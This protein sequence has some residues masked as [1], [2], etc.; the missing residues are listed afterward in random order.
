MPH[1][2]QRHPRY[3]RLA[4]FLVVS[5]FL[6]LRAPYPI[7]DY[8]ATTVGYP[9]DPSLPSRVERAELAYRQ[10]VEKRQSL[11]RKHGPSPSQVL[12]YVCRSSLGEPVADIM[13]RFP[14]DHE[15]WPAYTVCE[16]IHFAKRTAGRQ[17]CTCRGLLS[18]SLQLS[19]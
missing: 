2:L 13:T 1:V 14:P 15:P 8:S 12:L 4:A 6:Y 11:I 17:T 16:W 5:S 19:T 3:V 9:G 7:H 10:V 18:G